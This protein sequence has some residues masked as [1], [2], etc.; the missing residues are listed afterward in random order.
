MSSRRVTGWNSLPGLCSQVD[1]PESASSFR[2][3]GHA[4]MAPAEQ[5]KG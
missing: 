2:E 1:F 4:M 5:W 3:V